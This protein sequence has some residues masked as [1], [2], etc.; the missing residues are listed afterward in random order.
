[1][2]F[3]SNVKITM[4]MLVAGLWLVSCSE[5]TP[6][7]GG[8]TGGGGTTDTPTTVDLHSGSGQVTSVSTV[9]PGATFSVNLVASMGT[10]SMRTIQVFENEVSIDASR[11]TYDGNNAAA[12]P[13]LLFGASKKFFNTFIV[14]KAHTEV[15]TKTYKFTVTDVNG[16]AKSVSV[17]ITTDGTPPTLEIN[18]S[19]TVNVNP[20][21]LNLINITATQGTGLIASLAVELNGELMDIAGLEIDDLPFNSNPQGLGEGFDM[22]F[23]MSKL[24]IRAPQ[25][26]GTYVLKLTL[27]D[28]FGLSS[29]DEMTLVVGTPLEM[30]EGVLLNSA[31]P[32]GTGGLDLDNGMSTGSS[33]ANAEIRDQGINGDLPADVNWIRKIAGV[34]GAT[35]GYL[36]ANE[37]GLSEG[38]SWE[39]IDSKETLAGLVNAGVGFANGESN[40]VQ[41]GDMF[42]VQANG[43]VYALLTTAVNVKAT[44]NSDNYVFTIKK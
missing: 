2:K 22:G 5:D 8:G 29:T 6:G 16:D 1:M 25:T 35:V 39:S 14:V 3:L 34:N 17:E 24:Q 19:E 32:A 33:D 38:F 13:V 26:S 27:T 15:A 37:G 4:L 41:V 18:G 42:I 10:D 7:T 31:G 36:R 28:E 23:D 30:L 21:S 43:N 9:A 44:D 12:N 40:E 20:G 11:I